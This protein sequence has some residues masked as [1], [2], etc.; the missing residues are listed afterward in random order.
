MAVGAAEVDDAEEEGVKAEAEAEA[1]EEGAEQGKEGEDEED[2]AD[3]ARALPVPNSPDATM[4]ARAVARWY[5]NWQ[6]PD[7]M[8]NT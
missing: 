1:E 8:S 5:P 3:E 7:P 4:S 2:E 6:C